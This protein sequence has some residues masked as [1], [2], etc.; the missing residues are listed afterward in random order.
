MIRLQTEIVKLGKA[1][2]GKMKRSVFYV[3]YVKETV[4][5]PDRNMHQVIENVGLEVRMR[6]ETDTTHLRCRCI[7]RL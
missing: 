5:Y 1:I 7:V 3:L 4:S 6:M 2:M